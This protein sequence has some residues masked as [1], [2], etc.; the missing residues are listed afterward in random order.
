MGLEEQF[1]ISVEEE[2]AQSIRTVQ[3]AADLIEDLLEKK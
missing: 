1:G 2:R 3:D